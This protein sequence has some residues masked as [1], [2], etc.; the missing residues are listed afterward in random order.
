VGTQLSFSKTTENIFVTDKTRGGGEELCGR[1][2]LKKYART[3]RKN[4][5]IIQQKCGHFKNKGKFRPEG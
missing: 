2:R 5:E 1:E 3:V 4:V